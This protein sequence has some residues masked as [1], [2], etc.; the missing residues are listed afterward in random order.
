MCVVLTLTEV[1][2]SKRFELLTKSKTIW[3]SFMIKNMSA[4]YLN[5]INSSD[6]H[7]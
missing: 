4:D 5:K 3:Y 1:H 2:A 6:S 7:D